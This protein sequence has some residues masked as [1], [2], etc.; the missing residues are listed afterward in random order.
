MRRVK[1]DAG[2]VTA[3]AGAR[4]RVLREGLPYGAV[5]ATAG[6]SAVASRCGLHALVAPLLALAVLQALWL[7]LAGTWRHRRGFGSVCRACCAIGPA[8]EHSGVH[9]VP[10]GLAVIAGGLATLAASGEEPWLPAVAWALL[11]VTWLLTAVCVVRFAWSLVSRRAPLHRVDGAWFLV[12]AALL[13]AGIATDAM[14]RVASGAASAGLATLALAIVVC[15]WFGYW[16]VAGVALVRVRRFGLGGV[17]QAPWWIAMGCAG[18]AAAALGV[19]LQA[20][21]TEGWLQAWPMGALV[22][23]VVVAIILCVPVLLG[24]TRFLLQRC[25][26]RGFAA[27]PPTF[28]TAVFALGCLE[29]GVVLKSPALHGLGLGAGYATLVLWAVTFAWNA[30]CTCVTRFGRW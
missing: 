13:A 9:T 4:S 11:V 2:R 14:A 19:A 26:Y 15:G 29:A 21:A 6:A 5:M 12:P 30:R 3:V 1:P 7:P 27:W 23:T 18:L 25:R 22:V 17:A 10:L 20:R 28:S 8:H 16:A 24:S